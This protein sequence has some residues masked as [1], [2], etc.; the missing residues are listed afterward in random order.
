VKSVQAEGRSVE[1][2][3]R[4][5]LAETGWAEDEVEVEVLSDATTGVLG[6]F[7]RRRTVVV[8]VRQREQEAEGPVAFL[9]ELVRLLGLGPASVRAREMSD[10]VLVELSGPEV[11]LLIGRRG[12][13]LESL[14]TVVGAV[15][16]RRSPEHKRVI[17][18]IEGYR[19]KRQATLERLAARLAERAHRTGARVMLEPMSAADRRIIHLALRDNPFVTTHSE[20]E[21]PRRRVVISPRGGPRGRQGRA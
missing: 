21:E 11:G 18:D 15:V 12:A 1:E 20:G 3:V 17:V 6:W 16:A 4:Q 5:A 9:R 13:V 2:A 14:Q 7:G 8:R 19:R 10:H